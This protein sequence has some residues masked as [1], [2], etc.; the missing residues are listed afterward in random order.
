[1]KKE[2]KFIKFRAMFFMLFAFIAFFVVQNNNKIDALDCSWGKK[3][4]VVTISK[5]DPNGGDISGGVEKCVGG[6]IGGSGSSTTLK[7]DKVNPGY[8]FAGWKMMQILMQNMILVK[9][10]Q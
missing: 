5:S 9:A 8:R 4:F 10:K 6:L 1:M 3:A 2:R 7:V